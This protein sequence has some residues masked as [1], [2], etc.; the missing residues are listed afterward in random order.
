MQKQTAV[1]RVSNEPKYGIRIET[2][3]ISVNE[4]DTKEIQFYLKRIKEVLEK[5]HNGIQVDFVISK[6]EKISKDKV[7]RWAVVSPI[8][9]VNP[10]PMLYRLIMRNEHEWTTT[11]F[12]GSN[13]LTFDADNK[14]F[15]CDAEKQ[16]IMVYNLLP[17]ILVN[18]DNNLSETIYKLN[19]KLFDVR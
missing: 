4:L 17:T 6:R 19:R 15:F 1:N 5:N 13:F 9:R 11:L 14:R 10:V 2:R 8:N 7:I 3:N 12:E 18:E 16:L